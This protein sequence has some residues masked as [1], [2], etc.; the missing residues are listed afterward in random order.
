MDPGTPDRI[1]QMWKCCGLRN[2]SG[3]QHLLDALHGNRVSRG[4][5]Q[6]AQP[7][8]VRRPRGGARGGWVCRDRENRGR[9]VVDGMVKDVDTG[10]GWGTRGVQFFHLKGLFPCIFTGPRAS[11]AGRGATAPGVAPVDGFRDL[12]ASGLVKMQGSGHPRARGPVKMQGSGDPPGD[13][14]G[15]SGRR[16]RKNAGIRAPPGA[17]TRKNAGIRGPP[18]GLFWPVRAPD[19]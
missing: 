18:W 8:R 14:F 11:E 13:G 16:T 2:F 3:S 15:R 7:I 5:R 1:L 4:R 6:W 9:I 19:P 10:G 17:G 12:P